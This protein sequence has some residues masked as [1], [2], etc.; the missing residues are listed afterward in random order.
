MSEWDD[1]GYQNANE[2]SWP[3][4]PDEFTYDSAYIAEESFISEIGSDKTLTHRKRVLKEI[5]D[6]E[7]KYLSDLYVLYLFYITPLKDSSRFPEVVASPK[8]DITVCISFIILLIIQRF[9]FQ[10]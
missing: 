6:T 8:G 7:D 1:Q 5:Y 10:L 9:F 2:E 3:N 4:E